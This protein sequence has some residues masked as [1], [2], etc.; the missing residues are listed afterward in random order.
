MVYPLQ[1]TAYRHANGGSGAP[2]IHEEVA[3]KFTA[4]SAEGDFQVG[5][6]NGLTP[7]PLRSR[8]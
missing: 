4:D 3:P 6:Q 2:G 5:P 1:K 7:A 8:L